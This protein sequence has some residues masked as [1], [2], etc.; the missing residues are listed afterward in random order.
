[1]TVTFHRAENVGSLLRP[2][3]LL[4]ARDRHA[5]GELSDAGFKRVEDRAVDEAVALQ[6]RVGIDVVTDGE[7]RR[8]VFASQLVQASDGFE[9]VTGN[10]VDWF[11]LDGEVERSPV[12]VA[13]TGKLRRRRHFCAEEL[14]YLRART[15]LPVK[16]TVPSPTMYAYYWAPGISDG[17]YSSSQAYLEDVTDLLRDEVAELVRLGAEYVQID[18]PELGML[19]DPHQ[20]EWF[21]AKGFD[22]DR[23]IHDAVELSNAVV[24]GT[25]ARVGLHVCRGNDAN[26]YMARGGYERL[27]REVFPRTAAD[28]L[29]LEYDDERSGGFAP[30]AH[31]PDDKIVVLGLVSSKRPELESEE[32]LRAR[33]DEAAAIVPLERLALSTQCGF[34]SVAK[35]NDLTVEEEERK[36]ALVTRVARAVWA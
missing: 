26:R 30:L 14:S 5:R 22:A 21:A 6:E 23:L 31:V 16:A 13:V 11:T 27:A 12:T 18:A 7:Q 15:S 19:L 33:I 2:D 34:A 10:E 9:A 29:L 36:L 25:P 28:V 35:G 17:A 4:E 32:E 24:A 3:Y 1:M 8:N 20:Q